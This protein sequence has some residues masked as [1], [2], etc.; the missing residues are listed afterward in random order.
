MSQPEVWLRGPIHGVPP[1]LM[2]AAHALLGALEDLERVAAP[3]TP[4]ELWA[5][6]G[7]AASV[8]FHLRHVA[9]S[10]GRLLTSARGQALDETQRAAL[11]AEGEPH[12]DVGE[13][14][15]EL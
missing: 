10:T 9:G 5:R 13:V 2:P 8:G 6:P 11:A 14:I 15:E 7:G 4:E 12:G 1:L 3:L